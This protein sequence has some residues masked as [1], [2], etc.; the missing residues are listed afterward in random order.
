M[1]RPQASAGQR[2]VRIKGA[3]EHAD[4]SKLSYSAP[5]EQGSATKSGKTPKA[6]AASADPYAGVGRNQPCPCGSGKK[7][8]LCH[9]R[10]PNAT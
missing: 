9:G 10:N 1:A 4:T 8:K 2:P 5:D 7:F 3:A 6:T